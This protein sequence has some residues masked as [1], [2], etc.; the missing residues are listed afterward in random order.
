MIDEAG[1]RSNVICPSITL[2]EEDFIAEIRLK[3]LIEM[4]LSSTR[5]GCYGMV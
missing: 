2:I 5:G 4:M 3:I 1:G